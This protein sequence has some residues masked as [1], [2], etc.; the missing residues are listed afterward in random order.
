MPFTQF[1]RDTRL[2]FIKR[3]AAGAPGKVKNPGVYIADTL[4]W[5][6]HIDHRIDK[7][8]KVFYCL[9]RNVAFKVK[10]SVKLGLEKSVILLAELRVP[11]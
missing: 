4:N 3:T 5:S 1:S 10:F 2:S 8:N 9:R 6:K 11:I 7:T